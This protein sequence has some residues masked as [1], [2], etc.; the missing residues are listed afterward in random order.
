MNTTSE[1][2]LGRLIA[3]LAHTIA[4]SGAGLP[5]ELR[6]LDPGAA[7][8]WQSPGFYRL[9]TGLIAPDHGWGDDHQRRWAMVLSGMA[10]LSH[11]P[12]LKPGVLLAET[13]YAERRFARL[14]SADES[15]LGDELRAAV[16]FLKA[17]D[18]RGVDWVNL[19]RLVLSRPE[20]DDYDRCRR[21]FADDYFRNLP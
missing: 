19:S 16:A 2:T 18:G 6:R 11:R 12:G 3:S 20:K 13:Q 17:R 10:H 21:E 9:F 5:A 4:E 8:R 15:H 1:P 7:D 14:L